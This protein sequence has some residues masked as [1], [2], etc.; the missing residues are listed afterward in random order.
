VSPEKALKNLF[1][2]LRLHRLGVTSKLLGIVLP[3]VVLPCL[4]T[5]WIGYMAAEGIVTRLLN[6]AQINLAREIAEQINQDFRSCRGDLRL[7][8]RLPVLKDYYYNRF[9][10]LESEAEINRR[11]A[12]EFFKDLARKSSLYYRI[13][14]LDDAFREVACVLKGAIV[15]PSP[16]LRRL[17]FPD[18]GDLTPDM[19]LVS[20]VTFLD[21]ERKLVVHM[22][23]PLFDR[24]NE[25]AGM[26][27]IDLDMEELGRRILSRRVGTEGYT[28]VM[29][30]N[31]RIVVHPEARH[32]GL[33]PAELNLPD[34]ERLIRIMQAE[35]Q[36]MAPYFYEGQKIAAFTEV[37]DSGW[38]IA[39][40]LPVAEFKSHVMVIKK[41]VFNIILVAA[42][43]ALGAGVFFSWHFLKPIKKL[44]WATNTIS[45]GGLPRKIEVESGDELGVL[46][47]SF[48]QMVQNLRKVQAELVKSEKMVSLG[49]LAA[50][51]AHEIRN[52]LNTMKVSIDM[53]Q[54]RIADQPKAGEFAEIISE[55]VYRL[56]HFVA[57]FLSY[58][59]QPPPK[60]S[61]TNVNELLNE[62]LSTHS[63]AAEERGVVLARNFDQTLPLFPL[64]PFQVERALINV[65]MNALEAMPEGG[66]LTVSTRLVSSSGKTAG[67]PALEIVF[68]DTGEGMSPED[69]QNAFDPFFT[70]KEL[71][72][73]L[74]LPLT[75]SIIESHYGCVQIL[76]EAG[77]GTTVVVTLPQKFFAGRGEAEYESTQNP[78]R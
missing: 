26:I 24:W 3:L 74:G 59:R 13:S 60:P 22:A 19:E 69:L 6:Q 37:E 16:A 67:E 52:P 75:Q 7:L 56:D 12:E 15:D 65:L 41:Q 33:L 58:A 1:R 63:E 49:R 57:D 46:T 14:Y 43:L 28:F 66:R 32:L 61:P 17:P 30:N 34:V 10:G 77:R 4:L 31:G 72:T 76:S 40:T 47:H 71:G 18:P 11:E 27:V 20:A 53:L 44:A 78:G 35:G 51:V 48:N 42:S 62:I 2:R 68:K 36:G 5:G 29:D 64:D 23:Q 70:T 8:S 9:Y 38:I 25:F 21:P 54:R 50:G 39:A 45:E 73:G 55:E